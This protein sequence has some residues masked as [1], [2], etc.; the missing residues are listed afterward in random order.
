[1]VAQ[2]KRTCS[3]CTATTAKGTRCRKRTCRS[4]LCWQH[5]DLKAPKMKVVVG[6]SGVCGFANPKYKAGYQ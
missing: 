2:S 1:M 6:T 3:Q 4:G 5:K